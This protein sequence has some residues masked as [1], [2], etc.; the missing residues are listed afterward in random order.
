[1][2]DHICELDPARWRDV[3]STVG[4]VATEQDIESGSA[5]FCLEGASTFVDMQLPCCAI[6]IAGTGEEIPMVVI[7]AESSD[8]GVLF[9]VRYQFGG[10][11]ICP[12]AEARL[13]HN[14]WPP[15]HE[16]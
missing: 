14:G 13:F 2:N 6:H 8:I 16:C 15:G 7:Q 12:E 9:G 5:V 4:R 3:P 1:M 10:Y 11:G